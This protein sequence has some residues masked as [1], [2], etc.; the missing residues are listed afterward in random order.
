MS[1]EKIEKILETFK[2][3]VDD[4]RFFRRIFTQVAK[5]RKTQG[6][7]E[8]TKACSEEY[9]DL[10]RRLDRSKV[11]ESC[12]VR[13]VLRTRLI[14]T[15]LIDDKGEI[16]IPL[17][18]EVI[19]KLKAHLYSMGPERQHDSYRQEHI[20]QVLQ[21]LLQNKEAMRLLKHMSKPHQH[22]QADQVIRETLQLPPNTPITDAHARRAVL[23]AWMCYLRQNVGSCFATAPA[24]I[25]HDEQALLFLTDMNELFGTGRLKRTFGGIEYSVP[26]S[27]SWGAGDLKKNFIF[28]PEAEN[29]SSEIWLSPGLIAALESMELI[30]AEWP[31]KQKI[32]WA[33]ETILRLIPE[34]ETILNVEMLL[35]KILMNHL[36]LTEQELRDYDNRPQEAFQSNLMLLSASAPQTMGGKNQLCANYYLLLEK[37]ENAFKAMADNALLKC[38]EFTLAS[39]AETK[40]EFTRWNLYSSLGMGAQEKGGIGFC[41]YEILQRRLDINN[42][43]VRELQLEYETMYSQV[44]YLEARMKRAST[45][46]EVEW[47]KIDYKTKTY[48]FYLLEELRDK[49]QEKG[50]RIARLH[51]VLIDAYYHLFPQYFQEVYDADMHE[52]NVG[53]YDDSPAG[54]R[55]LYKY[56]RANTSQWTYIY[57]PQEFISSLNSFFIATEVELA[58]R[59]EFQGLQQELTEIVTAIVN[60]IKTKEFLE[61][62]FYRMAAVHHTAAIQD[63]LNHLDQIEKKPWAYTS[64]GTMGSLVSCY[65]RLE[66]KPT[67]IARWVEN[68]MELLVF[69]LDTLKQIPPKLIQDFFKENRKSM[70]MHSPTHAFLLKP[71]DPE[72]YEGWQSEAFTY[73]WVRDQWVKS[74]QR[75]LDMI[76]MDE[77]MM[78]DLIQKL[79]LL[80]PDD[81]KYYFRK[82]FER[83]HGTM[84]PVEFR[85]HLV[86]TMEHD[87]GLRRRGMNALSPDDI[88]SLLFELLPL[89]PF[90]QMSARLETLFKSFPEISEK[91]RREML[92]LYQ[93][94]PSQPGGEIYG[95]AKSLQNIAKALLCLTSLQ[96]SAPIDW[97]V[98][99]A[100]AAR[101]NDFA[102]PRAIAF[103]DT[104]WMKEQFAFVVNP[105][106]GKLE[107]WRVDATSTWGAP[108][109]L[110][111]QWLDGSRKDRP[112]GIYTKPHEYLLHT[113]QAAGIIR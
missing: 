90:Y 38:W 50:Q 4:P 5:Q 113:E 40:A 11:Q 20:L 58:S 56:G 10:S 6:I 37:G 16:Q 111:Q 30:S 64:G 48:E 84:T 112:W 67:E 89:F 14:A 99:I 2:T 75:Y 66:Q 106:T 101:R 46:K 47:L 57:T 26:L 102:L 49:E 83:I 86:D 53:P 45:E 97:H 32:E 19:Q 60:H 21:I 96:T 104:N 68:P 63:P 55:L 41:I 81:F 28:K 80:V 65:F 23:A 24:I 29:N 109:G 31:L 100:E 59:D 87:P 44:K 8:I 103:A 69:F 25:V 76:V 110:W 52:V 43:K 105:G 85:Q 42:Q 82:V 3:P 98:K 12:A 7:D 27:I 71:R 93:S 15:L 72:F 79:L 73:T 35:Q 22:R 18:E 88:D 33:K 17:V 13:N 39:F 92:D 95:N 70:L 77:G 91:M 36:G 108:M 61:T 54:F 9:D 94:L 34:K 62:A 107:L 51:D 74:R 1:S 78:N